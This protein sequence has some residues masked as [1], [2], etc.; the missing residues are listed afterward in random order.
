MY[1]EEAVKL[2]REAK[3][4]TDIISPYNTS[5]VRSITREIRLLHEEAQTTV[6]DLRKRCA[7]NNDHSALAEVWVQHLSL[8]RNKRVLMAY[9][10]QRLEKCKEFCWDLGGVP[11]EIKNCLSQPEAEFCKEYI[12]LMNSYKTYFTEID[13]SAGNSSSLVPPK[14]LLIEVRVLK[15]CGVIQTENGTLALTRGSQF[16][17]RRTDVEKLIS[18]G[19]LKHV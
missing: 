16:F 1:A 6:Q 9:H 7:D 11:R 8:K 3:R 18:Q 15:D 13:L 19:F 5:V 17:V 14:D 4:T 10:R 2:A 12:Q